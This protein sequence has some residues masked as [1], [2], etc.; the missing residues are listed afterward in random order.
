MTIRHYKLDGHEPVQIDNLEEWVTWMGEAA[1]DMRRT[2]GYTRFPE[3]YVSTVFLGLDHN[4]WS[5]GPPVLFETMIF[6]EDAGDE[7]HE[8]QE[9]YTTWLDAERGH[10][11]AVLRLRRH[12]GASMPDAAPKRSVA[13][14]PYALKAGKHSRN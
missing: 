4:F 11:E 13:L 3:G 1:T 5:D 2:V 12:I 9:R 6:M 14:E 7:M 8:E 10:V